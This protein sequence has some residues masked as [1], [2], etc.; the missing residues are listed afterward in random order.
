LSRRQC[1][2]RDHDQC[3]QGRFIR[4]IRNSNPDYFDSSRLQ[5]LILSLIP[6]ALHAAPV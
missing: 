2:G 3:P 4:H 5:K 6:F 1:D